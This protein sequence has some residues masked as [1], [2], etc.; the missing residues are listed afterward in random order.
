MFIYYRCKHSVDNVNNSK[1]YN[2]KDHAH[3]KQQTRNFIFLHAVHADSSLA[4]FSALKME[5]IHSSETSVHIRSTRRHIPKDG[6][7]HSS[8]MFTKNLSSR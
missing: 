1:D 6:I 7:L 4:D 8:G 3:I 5:A 2:L